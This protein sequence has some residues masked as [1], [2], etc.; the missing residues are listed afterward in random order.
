[1]TKRKARRKHSE[2]APK[3]NASECVVEAVVVGA[4]ARWTDLDRPLKTQEEIAAWYAA[5]EQE[6]A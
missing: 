3:R 4:W 1:M 5:N 6:E 2:V